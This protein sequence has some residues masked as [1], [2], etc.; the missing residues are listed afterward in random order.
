[1]SLI[2]QM[3]FSVPQGSHVRLEHRL[4]GWWIF[5]L[6]SA[7]SG[8][9]YTLLVAFLDVFGIWYDMTRTTLKQVNIIGS[10]ALKRSPP[11]SNGGWKL[12][13]CGFCC[14]VWSKSFQCC[15][16]PGGP[17]AKVPSWFGWVGH[18]D[19]LEQMGYP[20]RLASFMDLGER[21][22]C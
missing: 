13:A 16:G 22:A 18:L 15:C 17:H 4:I 14:N 11:V 20:D 9:C 7:T 21:W 12:L 1:M 3:F 8:L 5:C 19:F 10:Q 2:W 6:G